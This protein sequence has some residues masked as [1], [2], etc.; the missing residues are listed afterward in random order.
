M[1]GCSPLGALAH[2]HPDQHDL[3]FMVVS[4]KSILY[5]ANDGGVYR[6]LDGYTGLN[7]GSCSGSN[8]FDSLNQTLG[9]MTQFVSFSQHPTDANTI[10]GGT[11]DNGSPATSAS[12]TCSGWQSVNGGD[13]GYNE[14][15]PNSS[16]E[17]FTANTDVSIQRCT[18][19]IQL[20]QSGFFQQ[21]DC[22]QCNRGRRLRSLLYAVH[23]GSAEFR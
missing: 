22:Q 7:T 4:G 12:Q 15:N 5:F 14:I 8:H 1:Y 20:P 19:G 9:S 18:L 3:D 21:P 6:A 11:Q 2:V 23:S 16:N 17:W 13:G 10:L